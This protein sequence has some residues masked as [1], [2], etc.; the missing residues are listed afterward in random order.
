MSNPPVQRAGGF[1][2]GSQRLEY[3]RNQFCDASQV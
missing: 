1:F 3:P 2:S